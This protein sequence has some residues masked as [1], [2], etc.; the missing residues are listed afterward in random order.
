MTCVLQKQCFTENQI[1]FIIHSYVYPL[2]LHL[3]DQHSKDVFAELSVDTHGKIEASIEAYNKYT[4]WRSNNNC[5][6]YNKNLN[7]IT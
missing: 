5:P 3:E 2:D 6:I 4:L 1:K 7:N